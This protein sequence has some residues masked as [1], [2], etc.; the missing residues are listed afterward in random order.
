MSLICCI[1]AGIPHISFLK[2]PEELKRELRAAPHFAYQPSSCWQMLDLI[3]TAAPRQDREGSPP[4]QDHSWDNLPGNEKSTIVCRKYRNHHNHLSHRDLYLHFQPALLVCS[5]FHNFLDYSGSVH[6][7]PDAL[8]WSKQQKLCEAFVPVSTMFEESGEKSASINTFTRKRSTL[9]YEVKR[10]ETIRWPQP[11][12]T[13][14]S[15]LAW[16]GAC[17]EV[18]S[19]YI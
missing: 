18:F 13:C 3:K 10:S 6:V 7:A 1:P 9:C 17:E 16:Y 4:G 14:F 12:Q 15:I 11:V 19:L 5:N 8:C 2:Q